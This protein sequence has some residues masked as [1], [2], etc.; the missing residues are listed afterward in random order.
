MS[1]VPFR[2]D[3]PE[4]DAQL[5]AEGLR[6]AAALGIEPED[7]RPTLQQ[8]DF[9]RYAEFVV[10]ERGLGIISGGVGQAPSLAAIARR[11]G[12][13][14]VIVDRFERCAERFPGRMAWLKLP[15]GP[16]PDDA[17]M[18]LHLMQPWEDVFAFLEAY[19]DV[20]ASLPALRD[21]LG[22]S[23]VCMLLAFSRDRRSGLP[24]TKTYYPFDRSHP[25][26]HKPL[27]VSHRLRDGAVQDR[28]KYYRT[29]AWHAPGEVGETLSDRAQTVLRTL[30]RP[31]QA[32]HGYE[33]D[34]G[35]IGNGKLYVFRHD[36]RGLGPRP[37]HDSI[38][39]AEG[40]KLRELGRYEDAIHAFTNA[41]DHDPLDHLS[42]FSRGMCH[43][44]TGNFDAAL[45]DAAA[46]R[47]LEP[48]MSFRQASDSG[49]FIVQIV[50][51]SR[52]TAAAPSAQGHNERGVLLFRIGY[53]AEAKRDFETAVTLDP[54][55][56][57]ACN[58][59]GGAL[60]NLG[61]HAEAFEACGR[62]ISL[63]DGTD[64][65]NYLLALNGMRDTASARQG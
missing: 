55:F 2:S 3:A 32:V 51:L 63:D 60:I 34:G 15:F 8:L 49:D 52:R 39:T 43:V 20:A 9:T 64:T 5:K 46:A 36:L 27:I 6:L 50:E 47:T 62:A 26:D 42:R 37:R 12:V 45:A 1:D 53:F 61:R 35:R 54:G 19:P 28:P 33:M 10:D 13:A 11:L 57:E 58:N 44:L 25:A 17:T 48:D 21:R 40:Q 14:A 59:L 30:G 18:Y 23:P 4:T 31:Y 22:R 41:I 38:Y 16:D 29:F 24:V 65:T 7:V 56:A